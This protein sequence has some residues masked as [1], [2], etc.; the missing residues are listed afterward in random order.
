M[1]Y[2]NIFISLNMKS[3][4]LSLKIILPPP[5]TACGKMSVITMY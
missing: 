5:S 1:H 4:L 2:K 3:S